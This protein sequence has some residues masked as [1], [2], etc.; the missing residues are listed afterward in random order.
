MGFVQKK[1]YPD[2][3]LLISAP[4]CTLP[5]FTVTCFP[6]YPELRNTTWGVDNGP[7]LTL[8]LCLLDWLLGRP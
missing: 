5:I 4:A 3:S 7:S 1:D 8:I 2:Q 6:H